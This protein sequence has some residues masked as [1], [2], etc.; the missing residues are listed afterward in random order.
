[1]WLGQAP[2]VPFCEQRIG[3]NFRWWMEYSGGEVTDWV[4][5]TD[6]AFW[7]LAG[8]EGQVVSAD[9]KS[10]QFMFVDREMVRDFLLGKTP[11]S[12]MP[13]G[14]NT[15]YAFDVDLELSNGNTIKLD[16]GRNQLLLTGEKGRIRVNRKRL[17]GKPVEDIDADPKAKQEI[18]SLMA[19]IC[20]GSL[21]VNHMYNFF[22][23]IR[24]G[25]QPI[26]NVPDHVRSVNACHLANIALVLN[27][28]VQWDAAAGQFLGDAEANALRSRKQR[29]PYSIPT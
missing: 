11:A 5:H 1:M 29:E 13:L 10:S 3:W 27:R 26:A 8:D 21:P 23:C 7:A 16:S 19:R 25:K 20:G 2:A 24:R 28:K 14:Y 4:H 9:P 18:E 17:T 22:D 12:E 6:I 15:A